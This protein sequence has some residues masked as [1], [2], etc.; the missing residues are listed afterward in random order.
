MSN[1]GGLWTAIVSPIFI[2]ALL[3]GY[4]VVYPGIDSTVPDPTTAP[5]GV[6]KGTRS[7]R[8]MDL[9]NGYRVATPTTRSDGLRLPRAEAYSPS[10]VSAGKIYV[11]IRDAVTDNIIAENGMSRQ[12]G[13][14]YIEVSPGMSETLFPGYNAGVHQEML[15]VRQYDNEMRL[16]VNSYQFSE[17]DLKEN[18]K[19]YFAVKN[20][21][22]YK[23]TGI[24]EVE[25]N[26]VEYYDCWYE[27]AEPYNCADDL[28]PGMSMGGP[29]TCYKNL[30]KFGYGT[31]RIYVLPEPKSDI[32]GGYA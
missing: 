30:N 28:A 21:N 5:E 4:F 7:E 29:T 1:N 31:L 2:I 24:I 11:E 14:W 13:N 9:E 12:G 17:E 15:M 25:F 19:V 27:V 18:A 6:K 20:L 8:C 26:Q 3:V 23:D 10:P 32:V 22:G 16:F